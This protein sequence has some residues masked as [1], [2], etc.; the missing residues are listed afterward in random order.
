[1]LV[2]RLR[3]LLFLFILILPAAAVDDAMSG[4]VAFGW[5]YTLRVVWILFIFAVLRLI[6]PPQVS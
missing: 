1:M 6:P 4:I 2:Q 5:R 3:Y